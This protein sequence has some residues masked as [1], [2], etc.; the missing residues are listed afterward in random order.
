MRFFYIFF[1]LITLVSCKK[2]PIQYTFIGNVS[3]KN[4]G[5]PVDNVLLEISQKEINSNA[6]NPNFILAGEIST[7]ENGNYAL[8][9]DREKILELKF[10]LTN[11][12][13]YS[14]DKT[15]NSSE[16]STEN[17]NVHDFKLESHAW[18]K[19]RL[20]NSFVEPGEQL[21]FYKHNIRED[22]PDCCASGYTIISDATADTTFICPVVGDLHF[23]YSY[24]EVLASTSVTDSIYCTKNDTT[25]LV[26]VY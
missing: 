8:V 2:D 12:N 15:I 18:I 14:L 19:V 10:E 5:L 4:S 23:K 20:L 17:D 7:D 9:L 25:S 1:L 22:C 3:D 6:L 16:L 26:I 21:N 24:G 11:D 13:Y